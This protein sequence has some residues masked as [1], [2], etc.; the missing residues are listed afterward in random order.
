MLLKRLRT[1]EKNM[2]SC[3][4]NFSDDHCVSIVDTYLLGGIVD[5]AKGANDKK[6]F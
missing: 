4:I 3:F 2:D 6:T 1:N 5:A